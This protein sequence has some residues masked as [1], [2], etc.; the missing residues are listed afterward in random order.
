MQNKKIE[1]KIYAPEGGWKPQAFYVV[2]VS[3][4]ESN[5]IH[6]DIFYT[7]F[8]NNGNP[9]GY[10]K[11]IFAE[12]STISAA[13]YMKPVKFLTSFDSYNHGGLFGDLPRI[14]DTPRCI[15]DSGEEL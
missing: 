5:P 10:N 12:G 8:L 4:N 13:I 15:V 2:E 7:G 1:R 6:L 3:F 14:M 9:A 11:F